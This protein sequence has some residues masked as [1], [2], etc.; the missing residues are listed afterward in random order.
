MNVSLRFLTDELSFDNDAACREFLESIGA[1]HLIDEK[2]DDKG[3][4]VSRIKL[5]EGAG[6]FEG[7]RQAAFSKVDIKGQL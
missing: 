1:Q 3:I 5:K 4:R 7:R 2:F 6:L